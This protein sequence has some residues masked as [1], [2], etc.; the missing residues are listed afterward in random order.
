MSLR[1]EGFW[2]W[3]NPVRHR[4]PQETSNSDKMTSLELWGVN[5][6]FQSYEKKWTIDGIL[7]NI[8]FYP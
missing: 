2:T 7:E 8:G 1:P 4:E 5:A 3:I 6:D